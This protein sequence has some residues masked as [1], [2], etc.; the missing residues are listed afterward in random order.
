MYR[1]AKFSL[2]LTAALFYWAAPV[3]ADHDVPYRDSV[4]GVGFVDPSHFPLVA[5]HITG[6]GRGL[7][8]GPFLVDGQHILNFRDG[9]V[10][11]SGTYTTMDGATIDATYSGT[12]TQDNAGNRYLHLDVEFGP[13]TRRLAGVTGSAHAEVVVAPSGTPFQTNFT[14][15]TQGTLTFPDNRP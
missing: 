3:L 14:Y 15:T 9:T 1:L 2:A 10:E 13:G 4:E 8:L 11:G 7:H 12:F 5:V 6:A